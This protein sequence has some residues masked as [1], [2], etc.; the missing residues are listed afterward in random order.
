MPRDRL[1]DRWFHVSLSKK[2]CDPLEEAMPGART[3]EDAL[4][5]Y[6]RL[7]RTAEMQP[8]QPDAAHRVIRTA[9]GDVRFMR[10]LARCRAVIQL[11]TE[12]RD[13]PSG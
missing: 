10:G 3:P 1:D 9:T 8:H 13:R 12:L 2:T 4:L 5:R 7:D 11:M 6:R